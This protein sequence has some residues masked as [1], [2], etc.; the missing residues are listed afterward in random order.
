MGYLIMVHKIFKIISRE[1]K[2]DFLMKSGLFDKK[3]LE[4]MNDKDLDIFFES[5][6]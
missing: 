3:K 6:L 5:G 4:Q 2:I 1:T